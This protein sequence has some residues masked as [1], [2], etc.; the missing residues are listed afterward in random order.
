MTAALF[1]YQV[2]DAGS[3]VVPGAKVSFMQGFRKGPV[4]HD[5]EMRTPAR[6][7]YI[8][9]GAGR[10]ALYLKAGETY[11]ITIETPRGDRVQFTHVA[12]ADGE[13]IRETVTEKVEVPVERVVYQ[14]SPETLRK[15]A[16]MEA[17]L[18]AASAPKPEPVAKH[19]P[20]DIATVLAE[21]GISVSSLDIINSEMARLYTKYMG[22][23]E[24]AR[25]RDGMFNGKTTIE[26]IMKAERY[27]RV[28]DWNRGRMAEII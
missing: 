6:N 1:T 23:S 25:T 28:Q 8:T 17:L 5:P 10:V 24:M 16:E 3:R 22:Y 9:D 27:L 20:E 21:E 2:I 18:A 11:E 15:L 26:W 7:P 14:D 19:V 13:V 12:R 4:W